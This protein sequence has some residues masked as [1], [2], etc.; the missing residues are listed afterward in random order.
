MDTEGPVTDNSDPTLLES[1][2]K[3][4]VA[5]GKIFSPGIRNLIRD[6]SGKSF[7]MSWFF[8]DWVGFRTNPVKRKLGYHKI[9]DHY[10]KTWSAQIKQFSDG[11][12]WHYH[13]PP[14]DGVGNHWETDW[15][16]SN[17]HEDIMNHL[18]IDR[19][20]YPTIFRAGGTIENNDASLWLENHIPFDFSNRAPFKNPFLDWSRAPKKWGVYHPSR[21]DYQKIGNMKR[22]IARSLDLSGREYTIPEEEVE[23]AFSQAMQTGN[24]I[25]SVFSHDYRDISSQIEHFSL[26]LRDMRKKYP[27]VKFVNATAQDAINRNLYPTKNIPKIDLKIQK[28]TKGLTIRLLSAKHMFLRAPYVA[29][30]SKNKEYSRVKVARM[31]DNTWVVDHHALRNGEKIGVAVCDTRAN[32]AVRVLTL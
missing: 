22:A 17:Q 18:I 32:F 27:Q 14:K 16:W 9:R 10:T 6:D 12:Y 3:V 28:G 23:A 7:K 4:D 26:I 5:L 21:T 29:L 15:L 25:F 31:E 2:K 30:K 1:W 13:H 24:A 20:F 19:K 11:M 8:L